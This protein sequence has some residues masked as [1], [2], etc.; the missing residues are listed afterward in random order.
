MD[1]ELRIGC[2]SWTSDAW[3]GRVY[4]KGLAD[5]E[6]LSV[7]A[8]L[9]D[10]VEVD[11]TYYHAPARAVVSGW[12]RKTPDGFRF[13][14]KFPR[15]LLDPKEPVDAARVREFTA[16]ARLLGPKLGPIL[17]QFPTWVKPGRAGHFLPQLLDALDP[18]LRYA[19]EVRDAAWFEGEVGARLRDELSGRKIALAWSYLTYL[20][21]PPVR[22]AD[23]VYLRFIGDHDTIPAET[24]GE[25]RADRSRETTRWADRLKAEMGRATAAYVFFNNHYAG[26]APESANQFRVEMGLEPIDT[27]RYARAAR[28][29]DDPETSAAPD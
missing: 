9:F 11:S 1:A 19:V 6:R 15:D 3:W 2:S 25:L 14:L 28:R 24:H 10:T 13:T 23:F 8:R 26:F 27:G 18:E 29:L 12:N 16:S 20:D 7:Y 17:L 22:T 5:G 4:A 21:V